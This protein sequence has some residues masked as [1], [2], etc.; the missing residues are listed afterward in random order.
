[1]CRSLIRRVLRNLQGRTNN[2]SKG[3]VSPDVPSPM[4]KSM[5]NFGEYS[6]SRVFVYFQYIIRVYFVPG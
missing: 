6:E 5:G 3:G 2:A 1:M 4:P